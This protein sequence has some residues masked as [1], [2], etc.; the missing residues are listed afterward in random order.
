MI[1]MK[2][3]ADEITIVADVK[4]FVLDH[5]GRCHAIVSLKELAIVT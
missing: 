5:D 2:G 4:P 1:V 3:M